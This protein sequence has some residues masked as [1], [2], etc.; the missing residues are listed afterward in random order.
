[1]WV[2]ILITVALFA[3]L[4]LTFGLTRREEIK[5]NWSKYRG[6]LLY[7]FAAPLFKPD[8]DKRSR[9]EFAADNFREVVKSNMTKM[10][11]VLLAP[12]F[13]IFKLLMNATGQSLQGIFNTRSILAK[14][15][16][17]FNEMIDIFMRRFYEMFHRLRVTFVQLNHAMSKAMG[18]AVGAIYSGLNLITAMRNTVDLVITVILGISFAF[19]PLYFLTPWVIIPHMAL[20]I[21]TFMF[22]DQVGY[23]GG[24]DFVLDIFCFDGDTQIFTANGQQ[25]IKDIK[26]GTPLANDAGK[27]T[28]FMEFDAPSADLY[29]LRGVKVT[30]SHIVYADDG[31]PMFVYEHPAARKLS[32]AAVKLYSL[33]TSSR[34]IPV[35]SNNGLLMFADWEELADDDD[36]LKQWNTHVYQALNGHKPVKQAPVAYKSEAV[37]HPAAQVKMADNTWQPIKTLRPGDRVCDAAGQPTRVQGIVYMS[38]DEVEGTAFEGI[39]SAGCWIRGHDGFWSQPTATGSKPAVGNWLSLITDSGTFIVE[40][41]GVVRDFTDVGSEHIHQTYDWV[42]GKLMPTKE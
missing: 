19:L 4:S 7:M 2:P 6:D 41:V 22:A 40:G 38:T 9:F 3:G 35:Q 33:C 27:V 10:F 37:Y 30:G 11:G 20:V 5:G 34:R 12:L 26:I 21:P 24:F 18:A 31:K 1:M 42:L 13:T 16:N 29:E 15:W 8:D 32:P 28:G 17:K 36:Q 25:A 39:V 23:E 14:M